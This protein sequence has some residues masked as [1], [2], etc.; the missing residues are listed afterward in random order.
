MISFRFVTGV[1][2]YNS[3]LFSL[4]IFPSP[5]VIIVFMKSPIYLWSPAYPASLG[6]MGRY[7]PEP[8]IFLT[9]KIRREHS[10]AACHQLR[11]LTGGKKITYAYEGSG[12][13][14]ANALH[15]NPP[16][17]SKKNVYYFSNGVV[18]MHEG[19]VII[20]GNFFFF[21][22]GLIDHEGTWKYT[23]GSKWC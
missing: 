3:I 15:W 10:N 9:M 11:L 8:V 1:S 19:W 4:L 6:C 17:F 7:V 23:N 21:L 12:S 5:P 20:H 2:S 16:R 14:N 22:A 18:Y 13:P